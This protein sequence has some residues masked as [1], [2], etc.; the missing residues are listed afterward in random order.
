MPTLH[1]PLVERT[2]LRRELTPEYEAWQDSE[3]EVEL[4]ARLQKWSVRHLTGETQIQDAFVQQFF[5]ETWGYRHDGRGHD[6]FTLWA[7]FGVQGAGQ[8]GGKGSADLALGRFGPDAD[9]PQVL[10]EYK[11]VGA[12][13]DAPQARKGNDRS[14]VQQALDY[15]TFAKRAVPMAE[16]VQPRFAIVTDMNAFR[17]YWLN[18]GDTQS[19]RF[20]I[21]GGDLVDRADTPA[22]LDDTEEGRFERYL[23]WRLFRPDMLLS[24]YGRPLLEQ[25]I[26][27]QGVKQKTLEEDFYRDYSAFRLRLYN[28][29]KAQALDGVSKRDKL[30]LAQKLLDRLVFVLFAEDMGGRVAFPPNLLRDL[31]Q[32]ASRDPFF[33]PEATDWWDSRMSRLFGLM[34]DGGVL[35]DKPIHRFNGGLFQPDPLIDRLSLPNHLF[36]TRNEVEADGRKQPTLLYLS[37]TYNFAADG[38]ADKSIGL[39]TLGH[40]FEQSIVELEKLEADAEGRTSLTDLSKRKRDGVYYT[41]EPIV[42]RIV[43]ETV[44]VLLDGWRAE[45]GLENGVD[46]QPDAL[47]AYWAR[48]SAI[49]VVDPAC[50]SGAFLI[51]TLRFLQT[52]F[53]RVQE[54][55]YAAGREKTRWDEHRVTEHI[56]TRNLFGVDVNPLSV[57][58]ARLSLWLHTAR[59]EQP[60][61][62]LNATVRVGNSLVGPDI[63]GLS[64]AER[65][66][67]CP[68][69]WDGE[70]AALPVPARF[71][72]VIGNPP[73]VKLQHFRRVYAE[74]HAYLLNAKGADGESLYRSTQTANFDLYLPFVERG[75]A[76]LAPGGRLG[77]IAPNLWPTAKYGEG[78]RRLVVAGRQLDRWLDFRSH[79]VFDEATI[80][81]AIQIYTAQ[82]NAG[83]R[84]AFA[85]DGD[86]AR[87]DWAQPDALVPYGELSA[88]GDEWLLAPDWVR[89]LVTRLYAEHPKLGDPEVTRGVIVGIQ[90]S[91]DH[92]YHLEHKAAGRYVYQAPKP[93]GAKHKPAPVE[94]ALEDAIM[95]PL[96]SGAEAKR[97]VDPATDTWLLFPYHVDGEDARLWTPDEMA[98]RFPRA[99]AYLRGHEEELRAREAGKFDCDDWY[100]FGRNQSITKQDE[101][102]L[103]VVQTVPAMRVCFDSGGEFCI[104]NVRVNGILPTDGDGWFLLGVLNAPV[105]DALFRWFGAPK[106]GGYLE[107]NRQYIVPLPVPRADPAERAA[108][109]ALAEQLQTG[110]TERDRL[111]SALA[112]RLER[113]SR[114]PR[115]H[116][117]LLRDVPSPER[118]AA[119]RPGTL[120]ARDTKSWVDKR[121]AEFLEAALARVD[122]AIRLDSRL[123]AELV[124]GELRLLVDGAPVA[125]AYVE[126]DAAPFLLAQWQLVAL[127]FEP[128][129]KT[130]GKRLVDALRKVGTDAEPA[131]RDQIIERQG[132]LAALSA[133]IAVLEAQLHDIT[134]RLFG[135]TADERR[136]VEAR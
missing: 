89:G 116:D 105:T 120:D 73:Y 29:I 96:V 135:L 101:P 28:L 4:L 86:L 13:L 7:Q 20:R 70:F 61:S 124:D 136:R 50:G 74:T 98:E 130:D 99:W 11:G 95:R 1:T 126:A 3:H 54:L 97:F 9:T 94:V 21:E 52:E 16:P 25:M 123:A 47:D 56:L 53:G 88:A 85:R 26:E 129:G 69:D 75:L 14:P 46:P 131:L 80:Y 133:D 27:R 6:D 83:V 110:T 17:L 93:K 43:E 114:K 111:L 71:D 119:K 64:E 76:L 30:R 32:Q 37:R 113:V 2:Y 132:A 134:C 41:P 49:T 78:L 72:A 40:I 79:Q 106:A 122:A 59:S 42:R 117:W 22:L 77:Y 81:T 107:A 33:E 63:A 48:L 60:L 112:E 100:Q 91:A 92:I 55:R 8:R 10:C 127:T 115:P 24:D 118:I 58:I 45:A 44:G 67:V 125:S 5:V 103:M 18:K 38:D 57:E 121:A 51:T 34:N 90:T 87:V 23:F 62:S 31:L 19:L 82:P 36:C 12:K 65:E 68:F 66:R 39:Y 35:G 104:N 84:V 15:L 109:S 128:K 108:V 102:K